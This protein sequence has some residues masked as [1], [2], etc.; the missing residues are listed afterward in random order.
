M[1]DFNI[2]VDDLMSTSHQ[3]FTDEQSKDLVN[4]V[5]LQT[6]GCYKITQTFNPNVGSN[7]LSVGEMMMGPTVFTSQQGTYVDSI[8]TLQSLANSPDSGGTAPT[9]GSSGTSAAA[10]TTA[11]GSS[12]GSF[13]TA[14][15]NAKIQVVLQTAQSLLGTPY[16][17]GGGNAQGPTLGS[18]D[19]NGQKLGFDCSG[20]VLY[21]YNQAGL[22]LPH[23]SG[24]QYSMTNPLVPMPAVADLLPGDLV[25]WG[26]NAS[27]HVGICIGNSQM[28]DAPNSNAVIR[29]EAIWSGPFGASRPFPS[30]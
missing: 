13:S 28:I 14:N 29:T 22:V 30:S 24:G 16:Q 17:W 5:P 27:E 3:P 6:S 20:F 26:A 21:C 18:N 4:G 19:G 8:S 10:S 25:F 12:S 9:S 1:A 15:A 23:Y 7:V 11:S 2:T